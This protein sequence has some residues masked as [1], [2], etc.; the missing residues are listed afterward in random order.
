[1]TYAFGRNFDLAFDL[2]EGTV[3]FKATKDLSLEYFGT[4]L[5]F[6]PDPE[7][8]S[9]WIHGLRATQY[10]HK[11][12]FLKVFYQLNSSIEKK[13]IQVLFVYRFQPPFGLVQLAYQK[14]SAR[15]GERGRQSPMLFVKLA[16]MF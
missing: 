9:T 3:R 16:V 14:G 11:D 10:F 1:L 6:R 5:V 2:V 12:L 13:Y 15:L 4:R 8:E 7:G